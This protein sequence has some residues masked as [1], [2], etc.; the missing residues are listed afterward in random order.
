[1]KA[2]QILQSGYRC[3]VE[4]QDDPVLWFIQVLKTAE[5]EVDIVLRGNAVNYAVV[6]QDASG[7]SFGTWKQTQPSK[8]D[9]DFQQAIDQ[10]ITVYAIAE[11]LAIRGIP[12]SKLLT[13]IKQ[14][15]RSE[16]ANLF[17]NYDQVWTW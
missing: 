3:T 6:S 4:E 16:M 9:Q 13:G 5:G 12:E 14:I 2:L 15:S 1:M 10:G 8:M 7:L 17:N 11:D